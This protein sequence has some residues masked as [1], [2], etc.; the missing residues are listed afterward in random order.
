MSNFNFDP[1]QFDT[2]QFEAMMFGPARAYTALYVDF[3]EKLVNT[4]LEA[5]KAYTDTGLAQL[6]NLME[7]KDA[8]GLK[9]YMEGQKQVATELTERLKADTEKLV[10]LQQDF[11][12]DSQKL[13]EE[14]VQK[15]QEGVEE[16]TETAA[17]AVK[18][19]AP[20]AAKAAK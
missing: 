1:K 19:V 8:E 11:V 16:T 13:T 17:E 7:V 5:A 15:A 6:R 18:E 2:Q 3:T 20:K 10:A 4:Q 14:N 9:S 12:K